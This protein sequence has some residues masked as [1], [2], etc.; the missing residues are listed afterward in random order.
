[1]AIKF[2]CNVSSY[3]TLLPPNE[4]IEYWHRFF[5]GVAVAVAVAGCCCSCWVLI[6]I[7]RCSFCDM[8]KSFMCVLL[9][10]IRSIRQSSRRQIVRTWTHWVW[11]RKMSDDA[12]S[13]SKPID[14]ITSIGKSDKRKIRKCVSLRISGHLITTATATA[15]TQRRERNMDEKR[16]EYICGFVSGPWFIAIPMKTNDWYKA[17]FLD[18]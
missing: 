17:H 9:Y 8:V 5:V 14:Q 13:L 1:M 12:R 16:C 3:G 2:I 4:K 10:F 18:D 15:Q 7:V 6:Q 11:W